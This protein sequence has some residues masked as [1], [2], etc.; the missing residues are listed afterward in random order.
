M[1][2]LRRCIGMR[3]LKILVLLT[4][5]LLM[6]FAVYLYNQNTRGDGSTEP[7]TTITTSSDKLLIDP[8]MEKV[9][10][11]ISSSTRV[12]VFSGKL[13]FD[14]L[15]KN[16]YYVFTSQGLSIYEGKDFYG[17]FNAMEYPGYYIKTVDLSKN[18]SDIILIVNITAVGVRDYSFK[19]VFENAETGSRLSWPLMRSV[20][21]TIIDMDISTLGG[22][23]KYRLYLYGWV[24]TGSDTVTIHWK[25]DYRL[26]KQ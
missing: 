15:I 7:I 24:Y 12:K 23:G 26:L 14:N 2:A 20:N 3:Y 11:T 10:D 13:Y 17:I 19:M 6:Y 5:L 22:P 8:Y 1:E 21:T 18:E 9:K 16:R 25:I 4:L